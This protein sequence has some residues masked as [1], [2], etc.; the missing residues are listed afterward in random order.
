MKAV[1]ARVLALGVAVLVCL[2]ALFLLEGQPQ[3]AAAESLEVTTVASQGADGTI[4]L[5]VSWHW[6]PP[7]GGRGRRTREEL[8]AVSFD[9]R[10]LVWVEEQASA[11]TGARGGTLKKLEQAAGPDGAR[12]LFV[13]PEG[14][15]GH[16]TLQ[17]LPKY[18]GT[19]PVA[20]PFKVYVAFDQSTADVW[21]TET[22]LPDHSLMTAAKQDF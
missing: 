14:Q 20:E 7:V 5:H 3:R 12:R 17:F 1:P 9:T 11:G 4:A 19:L 8:L 16:V 6:N 21:M 18:P 15:D 2:G 10:A 22:A 13:M